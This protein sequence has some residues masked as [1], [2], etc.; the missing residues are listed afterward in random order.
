MACILTLGIP[1]D[2]GGA[3]SRPVLSFYGTA[4]LMD[5][6]TA[7]SMPD[8]AL[9]F[10]A[11]HFGETLRNTL[12]FQITP[13][14]SGSFRYAI[15]DGY[16][17]GI[18]TYYD[19]SFDL[20]YRFADEGRYLPAMALGLRDFGGTGV[21]GAEYFVA[22]RHL[23]PSVKLS[24][25]IGWGRLGTYGGF[26]NPFS[27]FS[28]RFDNRPPWAGTGEVET[29]RFFR[30]DAAFFGGVQWDYSDQLA[31]L[32]EYS[33]DDNITEVTNMGLDHRS[34]FNFGA[35]YSFKNGFDLGAYYM[36]GSELGLV[37]SYTLDPKSAPYPG[38]IE[39]APPAILPRNAIAAASW[40]VTGRQELSQG[41]ERLRSALERQGMALEALDLSAGSA[42]VH[43][44]NWR[45]D[46]GAQAIGRAARVLANTLPP[47]VETFTIVPVANGV[48]MSS[49]TIK[50]RDL[51]ELEHELDGSWKSYVRADISDA[52]G[53]DRTE[54]L[55]GV[56]PRFA[57]GLNG[58]LSPSLFDPD[59][60][61]RADIGAELSASFAPMRG[62]VYSGS[63]RQPII[64]NLDDATRVSDSVL[65]HVRSDVVLYNTQSDLELTHLTQ[66]YFFRPG[67]N[68]YGRVTAGYLERMYGGLST[69]LLWKPV[70]G[71]LALGAEL[72]YAVKRDYDIDFGFQDYDVMTGHASAYYDLG[73]GYLGQVDV[74]RYLA[75]DWGAT[76]SLDREFGNGIRVGA[77]FTLTDV[78]SDE[79][80]EG[81]FDK[82][83]RIQIPLSRL[84][85]EPSQRGFGTVIR[86]VTRDGGARLD[87]R[88]RLYEVTRGYHAPE[89]QEHWGRFWR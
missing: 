75:G 43:L 11:G 10:T 76:F 73:A 8:G 6:P 88:N 16:R 12:S 34:P 66:E 50:R 68:L 77:F 57:Y 83:I 45:Y 74:G 84:S 35:N 31:L 25:G 79:F 15:L 7:E 40:G 46:V 27:V 39:E 9:S 32:F 70:T 69:E 58:Y 56:Y 67:E 72:N 21:Y 48:P 22:T 61:V 20:Q 52:G 4:G 71:P 55:A 78:S 28:D 24:G 29:G 80:G 13:R 30:G 86:P 64:G 1:S 59:D 14:L 54:A 2:W 42:T 89:L 41:E 62:L 23:T 38:G 18:T 53:L 44:A 5:T 19:R 63:L 82:G 51:E 49:I 60:P 33:S 81:S 85:G 17:D 3:Q 47:S 65:P 37:L 36:Y 87:V 26:S